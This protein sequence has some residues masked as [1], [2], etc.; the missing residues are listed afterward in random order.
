MTQKLLTQQ[1]TA[2]IFS[3][4][5]VTIWKWTKS[6]ILPSVRVGGRVYYRQSDIDKIINSEND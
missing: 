4:S 2:N 3:V 6:G 1:E 5:R